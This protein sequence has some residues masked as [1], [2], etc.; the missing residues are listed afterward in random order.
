MNRIA[1]HLGGT[2]DVSKTVVASKRE[3]ATFPHSRSHLPSVSVLVRRKGIA[4][5]SS[6]ELGL[7]ELAALVSLGFPPLKPSYKVAHHLT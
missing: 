5:I 7:R 4:Y 2:I 3:R 6:S 1:S